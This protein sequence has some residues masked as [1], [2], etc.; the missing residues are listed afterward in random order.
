MTGVLAFAFILW[1]VF[2]M[3]GWFE[4]PWWAEHVTKP[5]GGA[6]FDYHNAAETAP[7]AVSLVAGNR[8]LKKMRLL[9][10]EAK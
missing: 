4:I 2:Q 5:L 10:G 8:P 7:W 6:L 3:R 1:H 9:F